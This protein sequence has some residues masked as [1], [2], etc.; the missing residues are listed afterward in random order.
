M[1]KLILISDDHGQLHLSRKA[2]ESNNFDYAFH[3]GDSEQ[4]RVTQDSFYD[5]WAIGNRDIFIKGNPSIKKVK[6]DGT[7][8]GYAHGHLLGVDYKDLKDIASFLKVEDIDVFIFGHIHKPVFEENNGIFFINP[9]SIT[10]GRDS[11]GNTYAI[12]EVKDG[13]AFNYELKKGGK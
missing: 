7:I 8:I 11:N 4:E 13:K 12:V 9:G 2:L 10:D 5:Y 1:S 3:L 6:I